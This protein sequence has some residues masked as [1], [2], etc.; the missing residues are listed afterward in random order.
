VPP[1]ERSGGRDRGFDK[2]APAAA[3]GGVSFAFG[4]GKGGYGGPAS[5]PAESS[6][7]GTKGVDSSTKFRSREDRGPNP[8][9]AE[10]NITAAEGK[11]RRK[12]KAKGGVFIGQTV[13]PGNVETRS[14]IC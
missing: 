6:E 1:R 3:R 12:K 10:G 5:S 14:G 4:S 11:G 13:T 9:A 7:G 2:Y 8:I